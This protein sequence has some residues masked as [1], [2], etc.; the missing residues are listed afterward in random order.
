MLGVQWGFPDEDRFV[1]DFKHFKRSGIEG[2]Y[3]SA[4]VAA[5]DVVVS[6]FQLQG[7]D[8]LHALVEH[9]QKM[10]LVKGHQEVVAI[11]LNLL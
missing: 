10:F 11:Q 5:E 2:N 9:V 6:V 7:V 4:A 1:S 8:H 3:E